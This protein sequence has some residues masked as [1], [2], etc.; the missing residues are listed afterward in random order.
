MCFINFSATRNNKV[1]LVDNWKTLKTYNAA[2]SKDIQIALANGLYLLKDTC[3]GDEKAIIV[4]PSK[5]EIY[6]EF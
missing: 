1:D 3:T 4:S 2:E 5:M 6:V